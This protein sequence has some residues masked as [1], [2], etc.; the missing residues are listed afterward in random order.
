MCYYGLKL[1]LEPFFTHFLGFNTMSDVKDDDA[2]VQ[3][4]N[5]DDRLAQDLGA[6]LSMSQSVSMS[7]SMSK[8]QSIF[9]DLCRNC[10]S[11]WFDFFALF[12]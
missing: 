5:K 12:D 2:N 3:S 7:Q 8:G 9:I 6:A 11:L 1:N 10:L 4:Q